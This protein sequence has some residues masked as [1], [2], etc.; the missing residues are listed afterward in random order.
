MR[1]LALNELQIK[2]FLLGI[3]QNIREFAVKK[4]VIFSCVVGLDRNSSL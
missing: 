4:I 1:K 3:Y 2:L